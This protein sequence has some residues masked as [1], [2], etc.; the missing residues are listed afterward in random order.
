[1]KQQIGSCAFSKLVH[2][3]LFAGKTKVFELKIGGE[4]Y[5][6]TNC[7]L[8]SKLVI[9]WNKPFKASCQ[10]DGEDHRWQHYLYVQTWTFLKLPWHRF[11]DLQGVRE[12]VLS[13]AVDC[14]SNNHSMLMNRF[15]PY[16]HAV[17]PDTQEVMWKIKWWKT[18]HLRYN[19]V[20][21]KR[22]LKQNAG[23]YP[24]QVVIEEEP[25]DMLQKT[26]A[27]GLHWYTEIKKG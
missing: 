9:T 6:N 18:Q 11:F 17:F 27:A 10:N 4:I 22:I 1:M 24:K 5:R 8:V 25:T 2:F 23:T 21:Y 19:F 13:S 26:Q 20:I 12:F 15:C 7:S 3:N 14:A 16:D